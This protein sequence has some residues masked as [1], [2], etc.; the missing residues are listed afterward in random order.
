MCLGNNLIFGENNLP[1]KKP[2]T[3]ALGNRS[4]LKRETRSSRDLIQRKQKF[5]SLSGK[6]LRDRNECLF[7]GGSNTSANLINLLDSIECRCGHYR[8]DMREDLNKV[9]SS[10][11]HAVTAVSQRI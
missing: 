4:A 7:R 8:R 2:T 9:R 6:E 1:P 5:N 10:A 3:Q 11:A